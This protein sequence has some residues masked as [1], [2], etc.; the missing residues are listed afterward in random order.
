MVFARKNDVI[1]LQENDVRRKTE[2][3]MRPFVELQRERRNAMTGSCFFRTS[4]LIN[5]THF[6][7]GFKSTQKRHSYKG[8]KECRNR[9][10]NYC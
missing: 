10:R 7:T 8:S 5:K 6:Q 1:L 3:G 4:I 9:G 2:I